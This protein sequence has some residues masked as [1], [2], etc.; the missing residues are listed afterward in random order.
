MWLA[1][2]VRKGQGSDD[3]C[4]HCSAV[5]SLLPVITT[6][7]GGVVE[8]GGGGVKTG[9]DGAKRSLEEM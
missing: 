2:L 9:S 4:G 6:G 3:P 8:G 7:L 1:E 5:M